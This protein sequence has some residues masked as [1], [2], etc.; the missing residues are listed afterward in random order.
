MAAL[1]TK[2]DEIE[3][4][5]AQF[6]QG[7]VL[8]NT[9]MPG[10]GFY[11]ADANDFFPYRYG[12]EQD[13][14]FYANGE[15][16]DE[17]PQSSQLSLSRPSPEALKRVED[18]LAREQELLAGSSNPSSTP[19]TTTSHHSGGGYGIGNMMLMYWLL[20]GNRG[21][22]AP[23]AAFQ[24]AQSSQ[25]AWQQTM[26]QDRMRVAN[27]AATNPGYQRLVQ[28]SRASGTMVRAGSSVRGGFGSSYRS[29]SSSSF[30]G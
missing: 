8:H 22:Y 2:L 1:E 11:H 14:R 12:H 30:G 19:Q 15:W 13:G 18:A 23:G 26:Q 17:K 25:Q 24:R 4:R 9:E 29:G 16:L 7:Y 27:H 6:T 21:N 28:Q 5:R 10:V 3:S 20:S